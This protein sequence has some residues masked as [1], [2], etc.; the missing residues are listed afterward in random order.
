MGKKG[1]P[2]FGTPKWISNNMKSKGLQKLRWYCQMCQKQCRDAN[3][4]KCHT[5]SES[6]QRQLLLFGENPG[7]YLHS[8]SRDF[9]KAFNDILRRQYNEK[10]V[11][12]NVVY[13]QY[14]SD[15]QHVHM[16][17]TCWVTL[18]SF[19][20]H[21]GRTG[22]AIIDETEKGW[23]ITW[24]L[25]DPEQELKEKK[26]AR[27]EK[28]AKDD[29]E[30]IKEY[31]DA[32]VEKAKLQAKND[33]EFMATE[34]LKS[35]EETVTLDMK[36]KETNKVK[37]NA[38]GEFQNALKH[39]SKAEAESKHSKKEEGKRKIIALEEIMEEEKKRKRLKEKNDPNMVNAWIRQNIIVKI[40]TKSLGDKYYKKKGRIIEVIDDFAAV[41]VLNESGS[42][43]KLDQDHLETVIPCVGREVVILW[44]QHG[45]KDATMENVDTKSFTA[46]LILA[47]GDKIRLPYEQFSKKFTDDVV[48]V[49]SRKRVDVVN[50]D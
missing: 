16:N 44:G 12:A 31:I 37:S 49:P 35:E 47:N 14:I 21:L 3:G 42:K 33:K 39:I 28:M 26:A 7:R 45:G 50:I 18:T 22:K 32:Q 1:R 11:H 36:L 40:V 43:L 5:M 30:R 13:Q 29:E 9:E 48:F 38:E 27:K 4:F 10:R 8:Y 17:S 20:K 15:K 24:C 19:V 46:K 41:V 25:K 2:E 6:H 23:Y 34:L